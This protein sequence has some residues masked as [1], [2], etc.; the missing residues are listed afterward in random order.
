MGVYSLEILIRKWR[1][2]ELTSEQ[3]IGQLLL[4]MQELQSAVAA[5]E[6]RLYRRPS[7]DESDDKEVQV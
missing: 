2:E 3:A 1:R 7:D 4:H 6:R 5:L